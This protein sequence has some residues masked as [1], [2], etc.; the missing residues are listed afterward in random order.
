MLERRPGRGMTVV[1]QVVLDLPTWQ[2]PQNKI[3]SI[4]RI[5]LND[6]LII[7]YS[8]HTKQHNRGAPTLAVVALRTKR[9]IT[10]TQE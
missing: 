7:Q 4:P 2:P 3:L 8:S 6:Y 5:Q 9:Q 1:F 10:A